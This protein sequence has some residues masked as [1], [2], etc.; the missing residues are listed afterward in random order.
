MNS[1]NEIFEFILQR[2]LLRTS[3]EFGR[4]QELELE[5][6]VGVHFGICHF[7]FVGT[8]TLE[9][10]VACYIN[11]HHCDISF[12]I[13]NVDRIFERR[14]GDRCDLI[15]IYLSFRVALHAKMTAMM[16]SQF[17]SFCAH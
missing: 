11:S 2:I 15:P 16:D 6:K 17:A 7:I 1:F 10:P 14:A 9:T 5:V 3:I 13:S 4:T 8:L 12:W